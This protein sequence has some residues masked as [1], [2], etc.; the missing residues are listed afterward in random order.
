MRKSTKKTT[1]T[2][3]WARQYSKRLITALLVGWALGAVIGAVYE[4]LRLIASPETAGMEAFYVY[5]AVPL[6]CGLPSYLIPNLLLNKEKVKQN[7]IPNYDQIVL[8]GEYENEEGIGPATTDMEETD[9]LG[10]HTDY[11]T[12][13]GEPGHNDLSDS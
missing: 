11:K 1:D 6:T 5:L 9:G 8:N 7:Y 3:L 4:F 2:V 13:P 12:L 10:L